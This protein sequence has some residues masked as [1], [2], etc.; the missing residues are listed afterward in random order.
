VSDDQGILRRARDLHQPAAATP[1]PTPPRAA[2]PYAAPLPAPSPLPRTVWKTAAVP[3]PPPQ[4]PVEL[5]SPLEPTPRRGG[6]PKKAGERRDV[7]LSFVVSPS[8]RAAIL[9]HL[10]DHPE[11]GSLSS[12]IRNAVLD[13]IPGAR[14]ARLT[15][16]QALALEEHAA[17]TRAR[18][19]HEKRRRRAEGED[20][21]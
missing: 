3:T 19:G 14:S 7:N 9:Q 1:D 10:A 17:L 4:A 12:L 21:T 15:E 2:R 6:R 20:P 16:Q 11:I 13:K 18:A 5:R 8:E